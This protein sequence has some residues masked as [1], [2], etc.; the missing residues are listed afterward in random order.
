MPI[1][2][3]AEDKKHPF[4]EVISLPLLQRRRV[5]FAYVLKKEILHGISNNKRNVRKSI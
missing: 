5:K 2:E 4:W 3:E 1:K